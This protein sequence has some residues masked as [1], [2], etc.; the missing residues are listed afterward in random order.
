MR[1][2]CIAGALAIL[3]APG[4]Y[5][6]GVQAEHIPTYSTPSIYP[7]IPPAGGT[8][9]AAVATPEPPTDPGLIDLDVALR[10]A[11]VDNPTIALAREAV[12]EALAGQLAARALLLPHVT[13]GGNFRLHNGPLLTAGGTIVDVEL[14]SLYLGLGAGAVGTGAVLYPGVRLFAHLGDAAYAPLAARQRVDGRRSE[15][16]AVQNAVL[17]DVAVTYLELVGAEARLDVLRRGEADVGEV[18]RLTTA[19]AKT[20]Q[21][22]QADAERATANAELLRGDLRRAE[23]DVGVAAARLARLLNLDP[24]VNL[25]TPGGRIA[26]VRLVPEDSDPEELIAEALR[27]RPEMAARSAEVAEARTRTKQERV[28]PWLPTVSVGYSAAGFGGVDNLTPDPFSP[29]RGRSDFNAIAVWT[30]QNLGAGN[31]ARVH[32][33]NA[34]LGASVAE[35]GRTE[36][37]VREEVASALADARAAATQITTAEAA[38]TDAEEGY[39]L[40]VERIRQGQGLPIEVLD[41]F[42]QLVD[43]RLELIRATVAFNAAQFRLFVATGRTPGA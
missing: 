5:T 4:C 6:L 8:A 43:T 18:V 35:F 36:N 28:R 32:G 2:M 17:R 34:V 10:L 40:E 9:P 22:R 38:L 7:G 26:P 27:A 29:L 11:G 42:R 41:S 25:R 15:A 1:R 31:R 23:E 21:G 3:S 14:R 37:Q 16:G 13:L 24:A 20:G 19:F 30:F 12:R 39:R 33:A